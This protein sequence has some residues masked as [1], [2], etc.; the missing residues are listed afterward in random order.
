MKKVAISAAIGLLAAL[1]MAGVYFGAF[2]AGLRLDATQVVIGAALLA[3]ASSTAVFA[4]LILSRPAAKAP[5][6]RTR[7]NEWPALQKIS[8]FA[9]REKLQIAA[10]PEQS[11]AEILA[12][13]G[14][15]FKKPAEELNKRIV[16]TLKDSRRMNFNPA[17]L[18]PLFATL[19]PYKL[20][21]VLLLDQDGHFAGYIPGERALKDFNG[22][23]AESKITKT[24]VNVLANP[25]D[26]EAVKA[27]KA[28]NGI[29]R[30][31]TVDEAD[32]IRHAVV[33]IY[34]DEALPG[35]VVHKHLRPLGVISKTDLLILTSSEPMIAGY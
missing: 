19:A 12:R 26:A 28:M 6:Q 10:R 32:D 24:I 2:R 16:L 1:A 35:L 27:L 11:L 30:N 3:F 4:L 25:S 21:H 9:D 8:E 5:Y 33:K 20:E 18:R 15:T 7:L 13:F 31:N 34:A 29:T 17:A 14:D 23:N 22:E